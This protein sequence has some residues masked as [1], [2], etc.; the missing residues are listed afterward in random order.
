MS[1]FREGWCRRLP[2]A[3]TR[4]LA[5]ILPWQGNAI[6]SGSWWLV[7]DMMPTTYSSCSQ[8][9]TA[10]KMVQSLKLEGVL[11]VVSEAGRLAP[12]GPNTGA[13]VGDIPAG[14]PAPRMILFRKWSSR[15]A[16]ES[17]VHGPGDVTSASGFVPRALWPS[18]LH[19]AASPL[20][21]Q[22]LTEQRFLLFLSFQEQHVVHREERSFE[23]IH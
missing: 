7:S 14:P 21:S 11:G 1:G 18:E 13:E 9:Q 10:E 3:L 20:S 2:Q 22:P 8:R 6:G 12:F 5:V 23:S 19:G 16:E 15:Y 4:Q 17:Q